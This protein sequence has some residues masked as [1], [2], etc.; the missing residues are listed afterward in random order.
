MKRY[1]KPIFVLFTLLAVLTAYKVDDLSEL[2]KQKL[3]A[4]SQEKVDANLYVHTDKNIYF[5][6]ETIWF[7]AYLMGTRPVADEVLFLRLV[8]AEN[9]IVLKQHFSVYEDIFSHGNI[10][11]PDSL[12]EGNY[13]L[14]A[15]TD[16]MINFDP[17]LCFSQKISI[18]QNPGDV[19]NAS[20]YLIDSTALS[21][22]RNVDVFCSLKRNG[23][24]VTEARLNYALIDQQGKETFKGTANTNTTGN[25]IITLPA[26]AVSIAGPLRLQLDF[27]KKQASTTL[28]LNLPS[29]NDYFALNA[30]AEGGR[31]VEGIAGKLLIETKDINGKAVSAKV[32]LKNGDK[33]IKE[34]NTD[35]KGRGIL[36]FIPHAAAIYSFNIQKGSTNQQTSFPIKVETAGYSA[37]LQQAGKGFAVMIR[38]H[39]MPQQATLVLRSVDELLWTKSVAVKSGDSLL[40]PIPLADT[41]KQVLSVALFD[42]KGDFYSERLF[43]N[44]V[45]NDYQVKIALNKGSQNSKTSFKVLV[46]DKNG[47]PVPSNLSVA[48][49]DNNHLDTTTYQTITQNNYKLS[50]ANGKR[51]VMQDNGMENTNDLLIGKKWTLYNWENVMAYQPKGSLS[52]INNTAGVWG[53]VQSKNNKPIKIKQLVLMSKNGPFLIQLDAAGNFSIP[54]DQLLADEGKQNYLLTDSKFTSE[55]TISIKDHAAIFDN[56]VMSFHFNPNPFNFIG[57]QPKEAIPVQ[58]SGYINLNTVT[59]TEI[60]EETEYEKIRKAKEN[61][62]SNCEDYV[63]QQGN[64][65]NCKS[66]KEGFSPAVGATYLTYGDSGLTQKIYL[67]CVNFQKQKPTENTVVKSINLPKEF[68]QNNSDNYG[69]TI[70]WSPNLNTNENGEVSINLEKS[71]SKGQFRIVVQGIVTSTLKPIYQTMAFN[72]HKGF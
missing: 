13:Q 65:L 48:V 61:Y 50:Q 1:I 36:T 6:G 23:I 9:N 15:Y 30:E 26:D 68:D 66:H 64:I 40:V 21:A 44:Q 49:V 52:V 17:S 2:L 5:V 22:K 69:S 47:K 38:N 58:R 37:A 43:V 28:N 62:P 16:K 42:A 14:Y 63:C 24:A 20:A 11:L 51:Y 59:I 56:K 67:K 53:K 60:K 46:T 54:A 39:N 33:V 25:V 31:L 35:E 72:G 12:A 19:L 71:T 70:Y 29:A 8:D 10:T 32:L 57:Y 45:K 55:Y 34:L 27:S 3:F 18:F 4:F 41:A 7:K